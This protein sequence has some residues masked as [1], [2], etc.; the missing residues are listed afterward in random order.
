MRLL[1]RA[2]LLSIVPTTLVALTSAW[3]AGSGSESA[4]KQTVM[5]QLIA[6]CKTKR[7]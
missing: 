1:L 4:M 3:T 6:I 2:V 7:S 5:D